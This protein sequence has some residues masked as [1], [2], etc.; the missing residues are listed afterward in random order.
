MLFVAVAGLRVLDPGAFN[1]SCCYKSYRHRW[2]CTSIIVR[3]LINTGYVSLR[4]SQQHASI[5]WKPSC[6]S[7]SLK[8][9][10]ELKD[11]CVDGM[12]DLLVI[13]ALYVNSRDDKGTHDRR[14]EVGMD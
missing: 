3:T 13:E 11:L 2:E 9:L 7:V 4:I 12:H 6:W 5:L 1:A 14:D 8:G 10:A